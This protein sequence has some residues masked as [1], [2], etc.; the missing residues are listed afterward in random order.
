MLPGCVRLLFPVGSTGSPISFAFRRKLTNPLKGLH[1][2]LEIE[3]ALEFMET[4][5]SILGTRKLK[6]RKWESF[7]QSHRFHKKHS[8]SRVPHPTVALLA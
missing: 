3:G 2:T 4:K 1:K 7:A 6:P 5:Y 8:E